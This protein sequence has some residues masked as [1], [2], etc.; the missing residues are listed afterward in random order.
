M[1]KFIS[2]KALIFFISLLK[3][4]G[5]NYTVE[6]KLNT[7]SAKKQKYLRTH[8]FYNSGIRMEYLSL[9]ITIIINGD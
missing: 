1:K 3:L 8:K 5:I 7:L 2:N 6:K 9:I 4:Y